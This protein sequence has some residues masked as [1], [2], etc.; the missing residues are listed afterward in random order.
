MAAGLLRLLR[1]LRTSVHHTSMYLLD[2]QP[3]KE[4]VAHTK[5]RT[6]KQQSG[7]ARARHHVSVVDAVACVMLAVALSLA[8]FLLRR[9][10]GKPLARGVL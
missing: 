3:P 4:Q 9:E 1:T 7:F 5:E 6:G 2:K 10:F 8:E